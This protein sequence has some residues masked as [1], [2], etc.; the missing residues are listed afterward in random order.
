MIVKKHL[1]FFI[2]LIFPFF[3]F[4][5]SQSFGQNI[6]IANQYY[7]QGEFEKAKVVYEK[8]SKKT[9]NI[10]LLHTNYLNTLVELEDWKDAEKY[11]KNVMKH[12]PENPSFK[13]DYGIVLK[14]QQKDTDAKKVFE[15]VINRINYNSVH[16]AANTFIKYNQHV[17]AENAYLKLRKGA[18]NDI[19]YY[20]Q[21]VDLY[22]AQSK[23]EAMINELLNVLQHDAGKFKIEDV[24]TLKA[25]LLNPTFNQHYLQYVQNTLQNNLSNPKY[26]IQDEYNKLETILYTRIQKHPDVIAYNE[27]LVWLYIQRKDFYNAFLQA[28]AIDKRNK[29]QGDKLLEVGKISFN[30]KDYGNASLI[31]QYIVKEYKDQ[32]N[33]PLA[34][35]YLI[36][37]R[38]EIV[39]TTY[40]VEKSNIRSLINDYSSLLDEL[41]KTPETL[42]ALRNLA[43]LYAFYLDRKDTAVM[44]LNEA[45]TLLSNRFSTSF[46]AGFIAKCK[47]DLGDIYL[48]K[49]E[50]WE[51]TL[52]YAQVEK[53]EKTTPLGHEAKLRNAKLSYYKGDFEW[54]Q[55]QLDILKLA[56]SREIANDAMDLSLLIQDN[57]ALDTSN[58]AMKDY[59]NA[60][61]LIFQNKVKEAI[62][63][64]DKMLQK[65][66]GHSLID[67]IYWLKANTYIKMN[68]VELVIVALEQ[69]TLAFKYDI[70]SD[71]AHF[72]LAK[73]YEEKLNNKE[74]AMELY[75][76]LLIDYPGSIYTVEA[77]KRFRKL[78]GD[79][80]N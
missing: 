28:K 47:L 62:D 5:I 42:E 16:I 70:L 50:H 74:K 17:Y 34:R 11:L 76:S 26:K 40:P 24:I 52:I 7:Q 59:A 41:G 64:L 75:K 51:S 55:A 49:G 2:L 20:Q 54:A 79:K 53:A 27:L 30:N 71:D 8:L 21:L 25:G 15:K 46:G 80:V 31:F 57:L 67:E 10:Q 19:L 69:I 36:N 68:E 43:H 72:L 1:F 65:Y 35:R 32:R 77:R 63:L 37:T 73:I 48:L 9:E 3:N 39:K 38:E 18:K 23:T 12:F 33:Y 78:R 44:I 61:L 56:T 45:I 60:E 58:D 13:I 14:K 6:E 4:S 22:N 29:T 66:P